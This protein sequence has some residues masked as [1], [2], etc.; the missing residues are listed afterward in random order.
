MKI[1]NEWF[2]IQN[3]VLGLKAFFML[4]LFCLKE[5]YIIYDSFDLDLKKNYFLHRFSQLMMDEFCW[6]LL[7]NGLHV[8][9]SNTKISVC[10]RTPS[11]PLSILLALV[12]S[13]WSKKKNTS[14]HLILLRSKLQAS[15]LVSRV[16][17][18]FFTEIL[19]MRF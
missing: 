9:Y 16:A 4:F 7:V 3:V 5:K 19:K 17:F 13:N 2:G 10:R 15:G 11:K 14:F 12:L 8:I 18:S 6:T 1:D